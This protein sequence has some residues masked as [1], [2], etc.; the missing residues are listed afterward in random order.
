MSKLNNNMGFKDFLLNE[1]RNYLG[2][3]IGD[4]LTS[5]QEI[6]EDS[7][8]LGM[9]HLS[10]L[11]DTEIDNMRAI[12]KDNWTEEEQREFLPTIQKVAVFL[13]K[14]IE[15][16]GDLRE[17][18][19]AALKELENLSGRLGV[20]VNKLK[21]V[22]EGGDEQVADFELTSPDP[23]AAGAQPTGGGGITGGGSQPPAGNGGNNPPVAGV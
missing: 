15:D 19:P 21:G 20:K 14:T 1:G 4:I 3:Q 12:L 8:N 6:Q 2:K 13:K 9:R 5:L 16:K 11:V 22:P 23:N 7:P 17:T 10:R 18:L